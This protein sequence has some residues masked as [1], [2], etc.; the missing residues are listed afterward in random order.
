MKKICVFLCFTG[1]GILAGCPGKSPVNPPPPSPAATSTPTPTITGTPTNSPTVTVTWTPCTG[2]G[3][4]YGN[5]DSTGIT[6]LASNPND[7][8]SVE[9]TLTVSE[10]VTDF[11]FYAGGSPYTGQQGFYAGIYSVSGNTATLLPAFEA[12]DFG[13]VGWVDNNYGSH[14][15]SQVL[16]PGTYLLLLANPKNTGSGSYIGV[17]GTGCNS[18][19]YSSYNLGADNLSNLSTYFLNG[20]GSYSTT[21]GTNC[22][23]INIKTCP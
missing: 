7:I 3:T 5:N 20:N 12:G 10:L 17:K 21:S 8:F 2:S 22:Y 13:P 4:Y 23:E 11:N 15:V 14:G 6:L 9:V 16:S 1:L 18:S 19:Y